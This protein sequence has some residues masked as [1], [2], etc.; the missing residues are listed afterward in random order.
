MALIMKITEVAI[1]LAPRGHLKAFCSITIEGQFV[2][3][4]LRLI[5]TDS[6]M[7][8]SMPTRKIGDHCP[9][10]KHKNA[11]TAKFCNRC[12]RELGEDRA[13]RDEQGRPQLYADIA[14]P[15]N[16]ACRDRITEEVIRA[17][18][19]E[20]ERSKQPGYVPVQLDTDE[21][22]AHS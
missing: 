8:V 18:Y 13:P 4:D 5:E 20:L 11:F 17:Y 19:E 12:A 7:F 22:V 21:M 6:G 2:I 1:K 15:I 14:H 10:C 3:R 16:T 9:T